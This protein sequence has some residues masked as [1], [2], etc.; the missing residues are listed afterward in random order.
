GRRLEQGWPSASRGSEGAERR[1]TFG[2]VFFRGPH[3]PRRRIWRRPPAGAE[4][5][6]SGL[7]RRVST[8]VTSV[9]VGKRRNRSADLACDDSAP[10]ASTRAPIT[11]WNARTTPPG[12]VPGTQALDGWSGVPGRHAAPGQLAPPGQLAAPGRHAAPGRLAL[13]G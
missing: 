4:Q 5:G 11:R 10:G 8:L 7:P 12:S 1:G 13:P 9:Y 6:G 2:P 3:G